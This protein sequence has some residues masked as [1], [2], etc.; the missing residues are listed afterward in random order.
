MSIRIKAEATLLRRRLE[1]PAIK[2]IPVNKRWTPAAMM[3]QARGPL[4]KWDF[5]QN[6]EIS[7]E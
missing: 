4:V 3:S 5:R 2:A 1:V 6:G 7:A